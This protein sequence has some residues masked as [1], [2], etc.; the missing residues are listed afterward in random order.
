MS[1]KRRRKLVQM[2]SG[3]WKTVPSSIIIVFCSFLGVFSSRLDGIRAL[4]NGSHLSSSWCSA[5]FLLVYM[6]S[7]HLVTGLIFHHHCVLRFSVLFSFR[8]DR[9][10]GSGLLFSSAFSYLLPCHV[11][12][13][14]ARPSRYS[15]HPACPY[16]C[17][18][19]RSG[20]GCLILLSSRVEW[21]GMECMCDP[22]QVTGPC[23]FS[24]AV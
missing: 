10:T 9:P 12:V 21:N 22:A 3:P 16:R 4:G 14:L 17:C 11:R 1:L 8:M 13:R 23:L 2:R 20:S 24:V 18:M 15:H 7:G 6:G 5:C 19:A